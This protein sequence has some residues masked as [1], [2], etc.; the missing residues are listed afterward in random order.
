VIVGGL[1]AVLAM[2]IFLVP[3]LYVWIARDGDPLPPPDAAP[4]GA[5]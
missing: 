5:P 2:S 1:M 4:I 3:C